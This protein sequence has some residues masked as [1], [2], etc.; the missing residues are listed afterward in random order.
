MGRTRKRDQAETKELND[1][2][3]LPKLSIEEYNSLRS[4]TIER[5]SIMNNQGA[6]AFGIV[7]TS[8]AAGFGMMGVMLANIEKIPQEMVKFIYILEIIAFL[9]SLIM[10]LPM[11]VKSGENLRQILSL[12]TYI[13]VFYNYLPQHEKVQGPLFYWDTVDK[14][15]NYIATPKGIKNKRHKLAKWYNH[16]Y[17][18]LG[19][20]SSIF[21]LI[22]FIMLCDHLLCGGKSKTAIII[23]TTSGVL[24]LF[25][26]IYTLCQIY[27][28]SSVTT[29]MMR[30]SNDYMEKYVVIAKEL[31]FID[32]SE[33]EQAL[34]ELDPEREITI[35]KA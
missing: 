9:Y 25:L 12:G 11:A 35:N 30:I 18:V 31:G 28:A 23:M 17:I 24:L 22:T 1:N 16:E 3:H 33:V 19:F 2:K 32:V 14:Q 10:L 34:K 26:L 15:V 21:T 27:K 29:N 6:S 7:L 8:W 20:A 4:E 13:R 5:I